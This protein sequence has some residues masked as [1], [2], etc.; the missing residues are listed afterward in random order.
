MTRVAFTPI[1]GRHWQGGRN[2]QLNLLRVLRQFLPGRIHV[3][4]FAGP[5][6]SEAE[7]Q[8]FRDTGGCEVHCDPAFDRGR[9]SLVLRNALMA[10]RDGA[11][12]EAFQ[13]ERVD[14]VFESALFFGWRLGLPA[15]AWMP[16]FQHLDL[17]QLFGRM[18]RLKREVGFRAQAAAGRM[19]MVSSLDSQAACKRYYP[20]AAENVRAVRFAVPAP[21]P[22]AVGEARAVA[23]R[24]GLPERYFCMPNQ[25][26]KHKNHRLVVDAMALARQQHGRSFTVIAPGNP[27]DPR[28]PTHWAELQAAVNDA[29]LQKHFVMP[30]MIERADLA[31]LLQ[32]SDAL[33][34]PSLMEGWSTTVEEARSA[35]VPMMLS[36]LSVHREQAAEQAVYFKRDSAQ[37][38]A[39]AMHAFEPL[40]L[41]QREARRQAARHDAQLRLARFAD[42][43]VSVVEAAQRRA[44]A[45]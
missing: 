9:A 6:T 23:D 32:A 30:G 38:L 1:G 14:V 8:E 28:N 21:A 19:L 35:G 3:M 43:F 20:D 17:P 26:W 5:D 41:A 12:S 40:S 4:V 31:P 45:S 24:Y 18:A 44:P 39:D 42:D 16:D 2:Y 34:N 22:M 29:G 11:I 37:S 13:R 33:L 36:D 25:Y 10:G 7:L 27:S 15:I